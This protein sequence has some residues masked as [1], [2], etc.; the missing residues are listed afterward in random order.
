VRTPLLEHE[1]PPIILPTITQPSIRR[2]DDMFSERV[3]EDEIPLGG[4]ADSINNQP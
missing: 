2:Y 1:V 4:T 3:G